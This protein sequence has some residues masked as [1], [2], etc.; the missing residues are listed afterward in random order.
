MYIEVIKAGG[1]GAFFS[2]SA[3]VLKTYKDS[4]VLNL[5]KNMFDEILAPSYA[6]DA[7]SLLGASVEEN[8]TRV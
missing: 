5:V 8:E 1:R 4:L 2:G 7:T 6:Q 3:F